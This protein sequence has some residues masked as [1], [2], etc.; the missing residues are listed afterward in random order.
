MIPVYCENGN[1]KVQYFNTVTNKWITL[2]KS[3]TELE[4]NDRLCFY[5]ERW[6]DVE[7]IVRNLITESK[8]QEFYRDL[9]GTI[10]STGNIGIMSEH[11]I[12]DH[13]EMSVERARD[14]LWACVKYGITERQ[15]G[16]FVV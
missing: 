2:W 6:G 8:A 12:A 15:G 9:L 13:M 11:L 4:A 1:F 7:W 3:E 16:G 5:K 14:M 10:H